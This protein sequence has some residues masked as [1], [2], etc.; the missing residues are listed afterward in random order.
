MNY[1]KAIFICLITYWAMPAFGQQNFFN[2]PS[3]D[4]TPKHAIFGQQ[5]LNLAATSIQSSTTMC[6]GL[7]HDFEVGVNLI[8]VNYDF[9]N[10]L[11]TNTTTQPYSPMY[12]F[13]AQ[14][15]I[16]WSE[17]IAI[18]IGA[19]LGT[20]QA[21]MGGSYLYANAIYKDEKTGT[22]LVGGLYRTS[23]GYFGPET[24]NFSD[25]AALKKLG[26]QVGIEKNLWHERIVF[27]ADFI[28][29]RH[30]LGELVLGGAYY[31][32]KHMVL[33]AGYQIPT[34]HS[35]SIDAIVVEFTWV[36]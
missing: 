28:S 15:K 16:T 7:G 19:Q 27:Q 14:K 9:K 20:N 30:T 35:K 21:L 8:G 4:I 2:V 25:Y 32:S 17:H 18:G 6:Y 34:F 13:N 1:T 24:R 36:P 29:G 22:K 12:T 33:S 10:Q 3:S 31:L 23:D 11:T 26:L 5:Q